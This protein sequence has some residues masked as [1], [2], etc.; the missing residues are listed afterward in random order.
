MQ[1]YK[2][3][4]DR[5]DDKKIY[6]HKELI[7]ELKM[8][9]TDLSESTYHWAIS[10]LV[11]DG[12]LTRLGYDS[13]SLSSAIPKYEYVPVYSDAAES[14]TG[15]IQRLYCDGNTYWAINDFY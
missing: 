3:V 7:D 11:R 6:G 13:Y 1:W 9:K 5:M 12:A 15:Y 2:E 8:L 14:L 4:L 10:D